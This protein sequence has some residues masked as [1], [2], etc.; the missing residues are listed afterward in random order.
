MRQQGIMPKAQLHSFKYAVNIQ[1]IEEVKL[2]IVLTVGK[3][4]AH[5]KQL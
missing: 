3:T 5:N 2:Y 4:N 1:S